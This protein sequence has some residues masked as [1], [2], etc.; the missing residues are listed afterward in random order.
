MIDITVRVVAK[1]N[2]FGGSPVVQGFDTL[3]HDF[4]AGCSL[5]SFFGQTSADRTSFF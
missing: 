1:L 3:S 2:G 4:E 5:A